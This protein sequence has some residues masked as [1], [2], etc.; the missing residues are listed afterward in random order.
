MHL[1]KELITSSLIIKIYS[2]N[3]NLII[4]EDASIFE[5]KNDYEIQEIVFNV[6][7]A[8]EVSVCDINT[9][10]GPINMRTYSLM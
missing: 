10:S 5:N 9:D 2:N 4:N 7:G 1:I 8:E 6:M 3:P